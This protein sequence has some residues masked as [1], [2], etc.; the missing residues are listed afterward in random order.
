LEEKIG[1][2]N[3]NK[4]TDNQKERFYFYRE[5]FSVSDKQILRC[6]TF[7]F[8]QKNRYYWH[9]TLFYQNRTNFQP[10]AKNF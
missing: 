3:D 8:G 9:N 6:M 1:V 10:I 2:G 7:T 4:E 5:D